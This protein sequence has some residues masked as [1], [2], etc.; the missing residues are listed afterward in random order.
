VFFFDSA[1]AF[2]ATDL[3]H[4]AHIL[5]KELRDLLV[6]LDVGLSLGEFSV[7]NILGLVATILP[8]LKVVIGALG[9]LTNDGE[10]TGLQ[11]FDGGDPG[12]NGVGRGTGN[13]WIHAEKIYAITY[14]F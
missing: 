12:E 6:G 2:L 8:M 4:S 9:S 1:F 10:L 7:G 14:T 5:L 11:A 3:A 13:I